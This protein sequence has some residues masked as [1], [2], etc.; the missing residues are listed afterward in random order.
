MDKWELLKINLIE[1]LEQAEAG[2][3][4]EQ[5]RVIRTVLDKMEE[6]DKEEFI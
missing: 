5:E 1:G 3:L 4:H 6:L 2:E